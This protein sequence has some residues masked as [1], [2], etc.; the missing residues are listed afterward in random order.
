MQKFEHVHLIYYRLVTDSTTDHMIMVRAAAKRKLEM[1]TT[2]A[3]SRAE[4]VKNYQTISQQELVSLMTDRSTSTGSTKTLTTTFSCSAP[5]L[6][7]LVSIW[8]QLTLVLFIIYDSDWNPQD[9]QVIQNFFKILWIIFTDSR[10]RI[11]ENWSDKTWSC[12]LV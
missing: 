5:E 11:C 9:I 8:L 4:V 1:I 7:D 3:R 6:E 2:R 10:P 12:W